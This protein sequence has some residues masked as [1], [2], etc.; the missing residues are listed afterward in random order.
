M[1][2]GPGILGIALL[3]V[4][5]GGGGAMIGLLI[6]GSEVLEGYRV[7][8]L[9][10]SETDPRVSFPWSPRA[11][12]PVELQTLGLDR[13]IHT[14]VLLGL[15]LLAVGAIS[16]ALYAFLEVS[17]GRR[18]R[19]T[20]GLVG[21]PPLRLFGQGLVRALFV[22][23]G[24]ASIGLG[25]AVGGVHL[26]LEAWPGDVADGAPSLALV[27]L[28]IGGGAFLVLLGGALP[29]LRVLRSGWLG[30]ALAPHAR[31]NPGLDER[32]VQGVTITG[33]LLVTITL[34]YGAGLFL[35][36]VEASGPAMLSPHGVETMGELVLFHVE[37]SH[38][39]AHERSERYG[40]FV[41]EVQSYPNVVSAGIASRGSLG[42]RG[43]LD[44]V[45]RPIAG[46]LLGT[47]AEYHSATPEWFDTLGVTIRGRPPRR[48]AVMVN[49]TMGRLIAWDGP[50]TD[51]NLHVPL[52]L[53]GS[54]GT[55]AEAV[56][57][58]EEDLPVVSPGWG[59]LYRVFP[60]GQITSRTPPVVYLS[61]EQ[62]P[63][64]RA[65]LLIR[66]SSLTGMDR[67]QGTVP[68]SVPGP[69]LLQGFEIAVGEAA[70]RLGL[71]V[72]SASTVAERFA[73]MAAPGR[74]FRSVSGGL[75]LL[76][77]GLSVIGVAG[78]VRATTK[79]RIGE[80][81]VRR[82]VGG[83]RTRVAAGVLFELMLPLTVAAWLGFGTAVAAGEALVSFLGPGPRFDLPL[84]LTSLGVLVLA[85]FLG[86]LAPVLRA[87][88][89]PPAQAIRRGEGVEG[90]ELA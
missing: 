14:L 10:G 21:A 1:K 11:L 58:L 75:T 2:D 38:V 15:C 87:T 17:A 52:G 72:S 77:I 79:R 45:L 27:V 5:A 44:W 54:R 46:G 30:D 32:T 19:A 8:I 23:V 66:A 78:A 64:E 63:S 41:Q 18:M 47:Q 83:S 89:V 16:A 33:Q 40:K 34:L 81:G 60:W 48:D 88:S 20:H 7:A 28:C 62:Y 50:R 25:V 86:A 68:G 82:A 49:A 24:G 76:A 73:E 70:S 80:L 69:K 57:L 53:G 59:R 61:F 29:V 4:A 65:D 13:A 74:W 12:S 35:T 39:P 3:A 84:Y 90:A 71:S 22:A 55:G 31:T 42:G 37:A 67:I 9:A 51:E 36:T 56:G 6:P 85:T 26:L 43:T